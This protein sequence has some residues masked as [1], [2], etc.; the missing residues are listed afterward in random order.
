MTDNEL[1][2]FY[3]LRERDGEPAA[4]DWIR[5]T[6][7]IYEAA[8]ADPGHHAAKQEYRARFEASII[9]LRRIFR[10]DLA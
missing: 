7:A 5:R 8:L 1:Y 9:A 10:G 6:L 2:R 4:L 3:L